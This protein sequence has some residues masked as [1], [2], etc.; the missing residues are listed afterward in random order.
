LRA[1]AASHREEVDIVEGIL[2]SGGMPQITAPQLSEPASSAQPNERPMSKHSP[3]YG[4]GLKEA[5]AKLL[6]SLIALQAT[7]VMKSRR[8]IVVPRAQ[9][10][11]SVSSLI[12][13]RAERT[14]AESGAEVQRLHMTSRWSLCH[15]ASRDNTDETAMA[16][17]HRPAGSQTGARAQDGS[18]RT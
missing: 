2:A 3:F 1:I 7:S 10:Y 8:R 16:G 18:L 6:Y 9:E 4:M 12:A 15:S 17:D 5:C 14:A 11:C 13:G